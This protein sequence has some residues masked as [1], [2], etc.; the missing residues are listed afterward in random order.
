MLN[1]ICNRQ[2]TEVDFLGGAIVREARR[3]GIQAPLHEALYRL[4]KGK[5][6]SWV[7]NSR[8]GDV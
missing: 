7:L 5:E 3:A 8:P 1:D 6:A 2:A 4:I